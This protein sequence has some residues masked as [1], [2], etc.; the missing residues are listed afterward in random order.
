MRCRG[1][2]A[3]DRGM[4]ERDSRP[5]RRRA[6]VIAAAV[7]IAT[8]AGFVGLL[9]WAERVWSGQPY[10]VADPAVTAKQLDRQTQDV[11]DAL[12]LP[13]AALDTTLS[14]RL[15]ADPYSCGRR[16]L[17]HWTDDLYHS[18]P[19]EPHTAAV[20]ADWTLMG[21]PRNQAVAAMQSA[22][23]QLGRRGW[24]AVSYEDSG[25]ELRLQLKPANGDDLVTIEANP[26]GRLSVD[27]YADCARY[28]ADTRVNALDE[29]S[30]PAQEAPTQLRH[31]VSIPSRLLR[32]W[33]PADPPHH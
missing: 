28:P 13:H 27:A 31:L 19:S 16:G 3:H 17:A 23:R 25:D 21:V 10:P 15:A 6:R 32:P 20:S 12:S 11:Y 4:R 22:R 9:P 33:E 26:G 14:G 18:P 2:R 29:P 1:P 8:V 30:L 5:G 7:V 24:K